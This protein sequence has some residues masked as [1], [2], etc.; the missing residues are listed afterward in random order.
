MIFCFHVYCSLIATHDFNLSMAKFTKM[1]RIRV[2]CS[3]ELNIRIHSNI[4]HSNWF[5]NYFL[6]KLVLL[7]GNKRFWKL[8]MTGSRCSL[9]LNTLIHLSEIATYLLKLQASQI[10]S[11]IVQRSS[12]SHIELW[13]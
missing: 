5:S 1:E 4:D 9:L 6:Y 12:I 8:K 3:T 2:V 10:K 11:S 13:R 7:S